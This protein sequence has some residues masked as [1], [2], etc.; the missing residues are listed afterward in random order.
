MAR[1]KYYYDTETCKYEVVK[2]RPVDIVLNL[3]GFVTLSVIFALGMTLI[4]S[5]YYK[6]DQEIVLKKKNEELL[7][8]Y[9]LIKKQLT[10]VNEMLTALQKRDDNIYRVIFEA[11][12]IPASVRN[13]GTGGVNRYEDL[14]KKGLQE[15][16]LIVGTFQKIDELKRKMYVQSKSY[17]EISMLVKN[18]SKMLASIPAIQPIN[19]KQL[20][21][22]S[23]G[24]GVRMHPIYKVAQFHPGVD[25]AAPH[26]TPIY[27]TGDGTITEAKFSGGYGNAVKI[28]HGYGYETYYAHMSAFAVRPGQKVKR[29]ELIGYV[30]NTGFS[31]APHLHYEVFY[32]GEW[33]NPVYYF[34]ND[35]KPDEYQKILELAS[36]ENQSLS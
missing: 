8:H 32:N 19:N 15:E 6:T 23:S 16:D 12:P 21:R 35:L 1:V 17:D 25:F 26:G 31:T 11:E 4:F 30:G 5:R 3:L 36:I 10:E 14:L 9:K 33:V 34:F 28:N 2:V 13:A 24:F 20:T 29:G 22:L 7:M 18:K 27:A